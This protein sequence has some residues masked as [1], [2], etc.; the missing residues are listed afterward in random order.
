MLLSRI[1][2]LKG[3]L[4]TLAADPHTQG[5]AAQ[6]AGVA[7]IADGFVGLEN[8]L[9]GKKSRAGIFG[10]VF[11]VVVGFV[12]YITSTS[13]MADLTAYENGEITTGVAVSTNK[14]T[15][16]DSDGNT[17]TTCS[18]TVRYDVDGVAYT[19]ESSL[20]S[21]SY[22]NAEG[23]EF[24]VSYLPERPNDGRILS[25]EGAFFKNIFKY[26]GL[27]VMVSGI[28]VVL[29]RLTFIVAGVWLWFWGRS[30]KRNNP[31]TSDSDWMGLL[32]EAWGSSAKKMSTTDNLPSWGD[33]STLA[34]YKHP[35]ESHSPPAPSQAPAGWYPDPSA[36]SGKRW[37]TG[38][39]WL[40]PS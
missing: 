3:A 32:Q 30:H 19:K 20:S 12:F 5:Q 11:I 29:L 15:S 6:A 8:P 22:C 1:S 17:S 25:K 27:F 10:G 36:P 35:S 34:G 23:R 38:S 26:A 16:R 2:K 14:S 37:W 40:D 13:F 24:S 31:K 4:G 33:V 7:L 9:D 28:F 18:V 39:H 21:S